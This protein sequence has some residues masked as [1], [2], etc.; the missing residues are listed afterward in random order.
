MAKTPLIETINLNMWSKCNLRCAY[1]YGDFPERPRQASR[2]EWLAILDAIAP[3]TRRVTFC[4]GEPTLN[5][6]VGELLERVA[7]LGLQTSIV[8]NGAKLTEALLEKI[9]VVGMTLDATDEPTLRAL[10]RSTPTW[11]DHF[12]RLMRCV[13]MVRRAGRPV[14]KLNTVVS[15]LN[16]GADLVPALLEIAPMKW[17]PLQFT[18]VVGENEHQAEA[19]SIAREDFDGF[20]ARHRARLP[21]ELWVAPEEDDTV[22]S[23]YVMVDPS[24]RLFSTATRGKVFSAPILE[25]GL[26]R[27]LAQVGGYDRERFVARGGHVDVLARRR[28]SVIPG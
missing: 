28:L 7:A 5:P 16:L 14:L 23:T 18:V 13:L 15:K 9:D 10:G 12:A 4:G 19:L 11:P 24:G 2:D 1:C 27:A 21:S 17:K 8:T 3:Y 26:E 22:R 20:V 6:H 25:V